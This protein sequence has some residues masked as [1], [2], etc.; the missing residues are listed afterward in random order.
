MRFHAI[1]SFP[2]AIFDSA[3]GFLFVV[4][5][6]VSKQTNTCECIRMRDC[7][8]CEIPVEIFYINDEAQKKKN[9]VVRLFFHFFMFAPLG[10]VSFPFL[11]FGEQ[12]KLS[13]HALCT[14]VFLSPLEDGRNAFI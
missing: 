7:L 9:I 6:Y 13:P 10:S 8:Y 5:P 11:L 4:V 14:H 2:F 1:S 3:M 12:A